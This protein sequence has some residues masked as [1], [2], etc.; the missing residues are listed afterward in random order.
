MHCLCEKNGNGVPHDHAHAP[1]HLVGQK[2]HPFQLRQEN[3]IYYKIPVIYLLFIYY[4]FR[5]DT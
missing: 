4:F 1:I 5:Q 2:S 3:V